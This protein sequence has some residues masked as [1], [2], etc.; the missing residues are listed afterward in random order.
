MRIALAGKGGEEGA[1]LPT[2][3]FF[4]P[5]F[6]LPI[7]VDPHFLEAKTLNIYMQCVLLYF[8]VLQHVNYDPK[9]LLNANIMQSVVVF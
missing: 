7:H 4:F 1:T 6:L 5:R 8:Y 3:S 9:I 2:T